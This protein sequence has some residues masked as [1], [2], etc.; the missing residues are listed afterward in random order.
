MVALVLI[1]LFG[2]FILWVCKSKIVMSG[3]FKVRIDNYKSL[4]LVH[5][6]MDPIDGCKEGGQIRSENRFCCLELKKSYENYQ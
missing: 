2:S 1:L 3:L 5:W 4:M 6:T